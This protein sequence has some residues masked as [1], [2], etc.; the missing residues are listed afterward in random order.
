MSGIISLCASPES[1]SEG[2][3]KISDASKAAWVDPN[4]AKDPSRGVRREGAELLK[5]W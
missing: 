4:T 2:M 5:F 1:A 3:M